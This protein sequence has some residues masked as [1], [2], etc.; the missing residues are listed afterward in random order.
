MLQENVEKVRDSVAAY[1]RRDFD[2]AV[3]FFDP[4]IDWVF[5]PS[6]GAESC[7][8]PEEVKRLWRGVDETFEEFGIEPQELL[9]AGDRVAVRARF[10]GRGKSS[11][12]QVDEEAFHH[13]VTFRDGRIVRIE[14]FTDWAEPS[15]P[16]GFSSIGGRQLSGGAGSSSQAV[17]PRRRKSVGCS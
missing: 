12:A 2:A 6:I 16:Q 7:H 10:H 8:G 15:K 13:V 4:E 3:E 11:G 5:P 14:H 1:N 17:R 9:D